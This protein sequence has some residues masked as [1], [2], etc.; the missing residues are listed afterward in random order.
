MKKMFLFCLA[1]AGFLSLTSCETTD[2]HDDDDHDH[3]RHG[4]STTT[5]VE[6]TTT[7]RPQMNAVETQTIR[8][9]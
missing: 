5:T 1:S 2:D 3:R 6:E 8:R 9:Y 4:M 7:T